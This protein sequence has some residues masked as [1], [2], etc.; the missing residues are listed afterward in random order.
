MWIKS[1]ARRVSMCGIFGH[2]GTKADGEVLNSMLKSNIDRGDCGWGF[3][4][5]S[6][7]KVFQYKTSEQPHRDLYLYDIALLS[8][9]MF[10]VRAPTNGQNDDVDAIHPFD[11][12]RFWFCHNGI[13]VNWKGN[14]LIDRWKGA[15]F[16]GPYRSLDV[17]SLGI[18]A[19]IEAL[20]GA[21]M[22]TSFAVSEVMSRL[23]GQAAC[24][25]WDKATRVLYLWR[26][27]S[28]LYWKVIHGTFYFSSVPIDGDGE[29][30]DEGKIYAISAAP[31]H[32]RWERSPWM[33]EPKEFT[34]KTPYHET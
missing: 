19:G 34:Y 14:T 15:A 17:D 29:L 3:A 8:M 7:T 1:I 10:H 31:E 21:N 2:I 20:I 16:S 4:A 11:T 33:V 9:S 13:L 12:E 5:W 26:V 22:L 24:V 30:L 25:L 18:L 23:E 32:N 6:P 27:M 28:T